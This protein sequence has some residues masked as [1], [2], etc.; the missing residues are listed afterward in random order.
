[1]QV[2]KKAIAVKAG[3]IFIAAMIFFTFASRTIHYYMTPKVTIDRPNGGYFTK[4]HNFENAEPCDDKGKLDEKGAFLR[5]KLNDEQKEIFEE[6]SACYV[7]TTGAQ[8]TGEVSGF[9]EEEKDKY[10]LTLQR[11]IKI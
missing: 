9:K 11:S 6:D 4:T 3:V 10:I 5:V 1:M 2:N 7:N 8:I